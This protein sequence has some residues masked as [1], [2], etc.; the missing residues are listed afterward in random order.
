MPLSDFLSSSIILGTVSTSRPGYGIAM[1]LGAHTNFGAVAKSYGK[2]AEMLD[3]GFIVTDPLY[4]AAARLF[5]QAKTPPRFWIGRRST[6]G[7]PGDTVTVD[8]NTDGDYARP[9]NGTEF[10]YA[11]VSKTKT[12]IRAE[13]VQAIN[14]GAE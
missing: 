9:I 12:Q 3:D 14:A 13:L 5:D 4:I 1:L 8:V 10:T 11:A 2:P 7:A 6:M